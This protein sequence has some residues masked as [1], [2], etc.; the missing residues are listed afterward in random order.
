MSFVEKNRVRRPKFTL[1][2]QNSMFTIPASIAAILYCFSDLFSTRIWHHAQVLILGAILCPGTRTISAVL[3]V[4]GLSQARSFSKY[5]RVLSRAVWSSRK[6][7]RRLFIHLVGTFRPSGVV[8]LGIDDTIE[9]R[10]G[11]RI[12]AKGIYRD[13]VRSSDSQVVKVSGLRWL[14][15]MLLVEIPWAQRVWALPFLSVLAPSVRYHQQQSKR[16][17][18]LSDWARQMVKQVRRWLPERTIIVV[19]DSSFAVLELLHSAT[20]LAHPLFWVSRL[21]MDAALY[22]PAP[23]RRP[24]QMGRP[25][26]KGKRLPTLATVLNDAQTVWQSVTL[27]HW[28]GHTNKDFQLCT[29]TALW[30]H[31]GKPAVPIRWVLIRDPKGHFDAQAFLCT[32]LNAT[33]VNILMWFRQ[34]WQVEVTF[35]EVRDHLGVE[36]QRQWSEL[37]IARTTPTLFGLFSLVTLFAHAL[38]RQCPLTLPQAAWYAKTLP[39]FVD[40]LAAVRRA[41]WSA[42][43]FEGSARDATSQKVTPELLQIWS[44]ILCYAA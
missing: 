44:D 40:A 29:G 33:A 23:P 2:P 20:Q 38:H 6:V 31:T 21:R 17:K 4:L 30:Y 42:R 41:L 27:Q 24:G 10:K 28:Y 43:L 18:T 3:R 34:R 26:L 8:V 19:G 7:A 36:T 5:H 1:T 25:R 37:A 32:D 9:R 15:L 12:A 22:E 11:K 35:T 16:H 39:T 13:A 14:S